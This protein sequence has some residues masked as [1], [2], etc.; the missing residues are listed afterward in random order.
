M[1]NKN[2]DDLSK[3]HIEEETNSQKARC[4]YVGQWDSIKEKMV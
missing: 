3:I 4:I 1:E 2:H